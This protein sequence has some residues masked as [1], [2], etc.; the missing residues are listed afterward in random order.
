MWN[1]LGFQVIAKLADGVM[2]NAHYFTENNL[3]PLEE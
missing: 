1:L 2:M 3:S